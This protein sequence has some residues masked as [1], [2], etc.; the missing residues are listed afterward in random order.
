MKRTVLSLLV[1]LAAGMV[2]LASPALAQEAVPITQPLHGYYTYGQLKGVTTEEVLRGAAAA[3][4]VPMGIY[5]LTSSRDDNVYQGVTVGRSPFFHG[6]RTTNVP[7]FIVPVKVHMPDGTVFDPGVADSTCL[8]GKL[9]TTVTQNSPLFQSVAFTMNSIGVGTTQYADA[10]LRA[11]FWQ[12]VSVTGNRFHTML[13]PTTVLAEQTF[14]VPTNKG[15]TFTDGGCGKLGVMDFSTW[16]S[17]VE[18]TLIPFVTA[19]GGG[20]TSFPLFVLYNVVM[21]D[22][23]VPGTSDNCCILGY[24]NAFASPVQTYGVSD[25]DSNGAFS[26]V[27]D[28]SAMSHEVNEWVNDPTGDNLT[29]AW[30][31][32]GQQSGCQNNFE[33][34]DPLSGTLF[35][36]V[37]LNSFTYHMQELAFFSWFYGS[38]SVG[39]GISEFSNNDTFTSDAGAVCE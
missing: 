13:S 30:G 24:H 19:H 5:T 1:F 10:F 2:T 36:S 21:A 20:P 27:S 4:T 3:T 32:I 28:I 17:F 16:D 39:T 31:H 37:T 29:P 15:G 34:G 35:P 23:F 26:G 9:P 38:P 22:P 33:V 11:E 18:S 6:S 7:T 14:T 25:F 8:G 12:N